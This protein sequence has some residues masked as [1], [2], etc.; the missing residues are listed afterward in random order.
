MTMQDPIADMFTRIRNAQVMTK[1]AVTLPSSGLK[2]AIA[3]VL[4]QE[5]FIQG[6]AVDRQDARAT[7]T[8]QL[9][10]YEGRPVISELA[11]VSRPGLRVYKGKT[12]LPVV[13]N[14]LGV[15]IVSTPKGVLSDREA[16][17]LGLGG[18]VLCRVS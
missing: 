2:E 7:L 17:R 3:K 4:E 12:D 13:K 16:R 10:Y 5:G 9:K 11:R 18:E 1:A 8:I 14:G 15:T 6:Y